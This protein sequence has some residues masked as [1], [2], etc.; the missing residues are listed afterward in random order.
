MNKAILKGRTTSIPEMRTTATGANI[1]KFCIAVDGIGNN[2]TTFVNITAF[3][4]TAEFVAK[5]FAKGQEIL[6]EGRINTST[7]T[8]KEG[9][10]RKD[11]RVIADRVEFC[12]KKENN[13]TNATKGNEYSDFDEIGGDDDL[14]F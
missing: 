7:Y 2:E 6:V 1:T 10:T 14:P 12:G 11:F 5:W 13:V 4:K 3:G 9:A 8:D